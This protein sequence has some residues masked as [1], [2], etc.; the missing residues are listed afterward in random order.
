MQHY[1]LGIMLYPLSLAVDLPVIQSFDDEILLI[2]QTEQI[3]CILVSS[4]TPDSVDLTWS[5]I[6][7]LLMGDGRVQIGLSF[8]GLVLNITNVGTA[9]EGV[10]QC[11]ATNPDGGA[12]VEIVALT[13]TGMY[14]MGGMHLRLHTLFY[15]L[16]QDCL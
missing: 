5:R 7:E 10:Y 4:E 6:D 3:T 9:D 13:V 16:L 2:G 1:C 11:T 15:T 8:G 12:T 14:A